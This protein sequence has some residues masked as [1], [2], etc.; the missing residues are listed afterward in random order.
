MK[1]QT[2]HLRLWKL[3]R[4]SLATRVISLSR[5]QKPR[6]CAK[7]Y[8]IVSCH[9]C[10][11]RYISYVKNILFCQSLILVAFCRKLLAAKHID[12]SYFAAGIIAH[13]ASDGAHVWS[14]AGTDR[15]DALSE[16]VGVL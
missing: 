15:E 8:S 10:R 16:L 5:S 6:V 3:L 14:V 2:N 7:I 9:L 4:G 1:A 11:Y 12:V 13:L